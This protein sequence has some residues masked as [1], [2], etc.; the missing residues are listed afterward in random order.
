MSRL[1]ARRPIDSAYAIAD[2]LPRRDR[3][4]IGLVVF[5]ALIAPLEGYY[6]L[7]HQELERRDDIFVRLLSLYWSADYTY[8]VPGYAL[9]KCFSLSLEGVNT[10]V[11]QPLSFLLVYGI[12]KRRPWRHVLQLTL[13]TYTF[14]GTFLYYS[15]GHLSGYKGF[16]HRGIE[17]FLLFYLCNLPWFVGYAWMAFDAMRAI[18][19]RFTESHPEAARH[20]SS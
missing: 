20:S 7:F 5:F 18:T 8:R 3:I 11:T 19:R 13:A 14:Y 10:L 4:V 9:E 6:V 15:V 17:N 16:A 2:R 12:V 1:P